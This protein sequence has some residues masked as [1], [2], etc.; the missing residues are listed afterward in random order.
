MMMN[1]T[2]E[3]ATMQVAARE[4]ARRR[5][6]AGGSEWKSLLHILQYVNQIAKPSGAH[7]LPRWIRY[8]E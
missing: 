6:N 5:T 7:S 2:L 8:F 4:M 3:I 1:I